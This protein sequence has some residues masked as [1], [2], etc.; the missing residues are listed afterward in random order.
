[1]N[2]SE[3]MKDYFVQFDRE[4]CIGRKIILFQVQLLRHLKKMDYLRIEMAE[5]VLKNV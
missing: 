3:M 2:V 4:I 5:E 1:M